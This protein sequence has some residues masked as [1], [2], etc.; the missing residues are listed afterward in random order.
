MKKKKIILIACVAVAFVAAVL[1][2][3]LCLTLPKDDGEHA[4]NYTETVTPPTCTQEG[5]T[6]YTCTVCGN[7]FRGNIKS[8]LGHDITGYTDD[9]ATCEQGGTKLPIC[10]RGDTVE[11]VVSEP[12]GHD[13]V[14]EPDDNATCEH[15]GTE[16]AHCTR[17]NE[18]NVIYRYIDGTRLAHDF[19][20]ANHRCSMCGE[21][22]PTSGLKFKLN[23]DGNGFIL[24][25]ATSAV[26]DLVI[27]STRKT[28]DGKMLPVTEIA[29]GVFK[30][31]KYRTVTLPK[32]IRVIGARAF[33]ECTNLAEV[34]IY[35]LNS[36]YSIE[37][38]DQQS[39]PVTFTGKLTVDKDGTEIKPVTGELKVPDTVTKINSLAFKNLGGLTKVILHD[40]IEYI[41]EYAFD[42]CDNLE[43][44]SYENAKYIGSEGNPYIALVKADNL[45]ITECTIHADTKFILERA[46][47]SADRLTKIVIPQK[48]KTIGAWAFNGCRELQT[49]EFEADDKH[50]SA[51]TSIGNLA[52]SGCTKLTGVGTIPNSVTEIGASAFSGCT[53][54]TNI[55][56]S[57]SLKEIA[58]RTFQ[59]CKSL[60][61]IQ[62]PVSVGKI[63]T[64]AFAGCTNL[65][66]IVIPDMVAS[67]GLNAFDGSGIVKATVGSGLRQIG[68]HVF[69]NCG[70]LQTVTIRGHVERICDYAFN[71]CTSLKQIYFVGTQEEWDA[72]F[73]HVGAG[74]GSLGNSLEFH[75]NIS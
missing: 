16:T 53:S 19:E 8:A 6:T 28:D 66:E 40:G 12:L 68:E 45:D 38:A 50:I 48:V 17:C 54:L 10:S 34:Y 20:T 31:G 63:G 18:E 70:K 21:K 29:S 39:N 5:Y 55:A 22:E 15:D 61:T 33:D 52:F 74:N 41:G 7:S 46:F 2:I 27:P 26:E 11:R 25:E 1:T 60:D 62:I 35:D 14:Y 71:G 73:A 58:D 72:I 47:Q 32:S 3:V 36:W 42:G 56:L 44:N 51:L 64:Y 37:F 49:V 65:Q 13:L 4:H 75:F 67:I 23:E 59:N 69:E 43:F 30:N 57:N 24:T 9:T